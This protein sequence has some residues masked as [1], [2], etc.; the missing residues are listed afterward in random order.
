MFSETNL[1]RSLR[2]NYRYLILEQ[3]I[4][5]MKISIILLSFSTVIHILLFLEISHLCLVFNSKFACSN[6]SCAALL[7]TAAIESLY[8]FC[9]FPLLDITEVNITNI[10]KGH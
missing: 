10:V 9:H 8:N 7:N 4:W 1:S 6:L 5:I 2:S 3:I